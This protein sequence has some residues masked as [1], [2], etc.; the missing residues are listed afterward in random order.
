MMSYYYSHGPA[1]GHAMW[2]EMYLGKEHKIN[3][4]QSFNAGLAIQS[5][6]FYLIKPW[7]T[8]QKY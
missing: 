3:A 1:G 5:P 6:A 7:Y 2:E 8:V 4:Q